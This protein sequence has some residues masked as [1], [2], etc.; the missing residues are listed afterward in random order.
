MRQEHADAET[1]RGNV[2]KECLHIYFTP[3]AQLLSATAALGDDLI[4]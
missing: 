2:G 4:T 3:T 1:G